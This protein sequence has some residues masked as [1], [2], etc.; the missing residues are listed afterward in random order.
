[1]MSIHFIEYSNEWSRADGNGPGLILLMTAGR[2]CG[3]WTDPHGAG[4]T[5][6]LGA[7]PVLPG[8]DD[9]PHDAE[10]DEM[11]ITRC[12][13]RGCSRYTSVRCMVLGL[14]FLM[15]MALL[16]FFLY[17][18]SAVMEWVSTNPAFN[19]PLLVGGLLVY[20]GIGMWLLMVNFSC[21]DEDSAEQT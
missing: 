21:E 3:I 2:T 14:W 20:L 17:Q 18:G 6:R 5:P 19:Q 13:K 10:E 11:G 1:M 15:S 8:P 12:M 7:G 16:G 4:R 9:P